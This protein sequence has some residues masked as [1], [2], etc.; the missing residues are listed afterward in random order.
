MSAIKRALIRK[1]K[2]H[3]KFGKLSEEDQNHIASIMAARV[4]D[5]R[6]LALDKVRL[7]R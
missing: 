2:A 1:I 5:E 3:E 6:R 7:Y 4:K